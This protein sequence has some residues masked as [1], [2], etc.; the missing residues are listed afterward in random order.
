MRLPGSGPPQRT[1]SQTDHRF[2]WANSE[3]DLKALQEI[4]I[5]AKSKALAIRSERLGVC[6]EVFQ[7]IGAAFRRPYGRL[8]DVRHK[9]TVERPR[10]FT[11]L[12]ES[13]QGNAERKSASGRTPTG[14]AI[15]TADCKAVSPGG[16]CGWCISEFRFRSG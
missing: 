11:R 7:A 13:V 5:E 1:G 10:A 16:V 15:M 3:R 6:G 4:T 14:Q 2:E 9:R 12:E 8:C